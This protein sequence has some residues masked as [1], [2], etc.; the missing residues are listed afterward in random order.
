MNYT[1]EQYR[2]NDTGR[3]RWAVLDR[4]ARVWYFPARYG[5]AA[6]Q[7]MAAILNRRA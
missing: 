6:A 4:S 5:R 2:D 1:A 3:T 7:R